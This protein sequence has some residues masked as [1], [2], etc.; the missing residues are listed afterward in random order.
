MYPD[1]SFL[2][3]GLS[4]PFPD[5]KARNFAKQVK[6]VFVLEELEPYL[7][8]QMKLLGIKI[9]AK[10]PS[11]SVGEIRPEDLPAIIKQGK[12]KQ[13]LP[14]TRKPVLCPGCGHRP[15]FH[16]LKKLKLTVSGDIGCYT[17]GA[18]AP[19]SSLHSC[20]CMGAAITFL[21]G[22]KKSQGKQA[23]L[24][25][26][27][28]VAVIGD[29]TFVHSGIAGLINLSYNKTKGVVMILDNATTAM[30]G[31]QP[32]PAT[33]F[34]A[35]L[36]PTKKLILEDVCK[37]CGADNVDV[38]DP[39]QVK[40]LEDILKQRLDEDALSVIICRCA[41][42]ILEKRKMPA[43]VYNKDKCIKCYLCLGI[44]CPALTRSDDGFIHIDQ[45]ICTGC[46][47][48]VGVCKPGALTKNE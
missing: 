11:Y 4:F 36:E 31:S 8:E 47:L 35:K 29:S 21:E 40:Q 9:K 5:E 41:C 10:H 17:L 1:A 28:V 44:N 6:E 2:K 43:P 45:A 7:E 15:V 14:L 25:G 37:A 34:T 27:Q 12:N 46:N 30:T 13:D 26:R 32:H 24:S 42:R 18:L 33:G 22:W 48:C 19:L 23:C 20:L 39:Y 38:V 16:I 3:L